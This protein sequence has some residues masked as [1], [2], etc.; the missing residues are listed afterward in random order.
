MIAKQMGSEVAGDTDGCRELNKDT[1]DMQITSRVA[2]SKSA[3][4]IREMDKE[5]FGSLMESMREVGQIVPIYTLNGEVVDGRARLRACQRLKMEPVVE[6]LDPS[7]DPLDVADALN[8]RRRHLTTAEL[9]TAASRLNKRSPEDLAALGISKRSVE[10]ADRVYKQGAPETIE[11]A[12]RGEI[13]ISLASRVSGMPKEQ[14]AEAVSMIREGKKSEVISRLNASSPPRKQEPVTPGDIVA[15]FR[16]TSDRIETMRQLLEELQD[17]ELPIVAGFIAPES[18]EPVD[19]FDKQPDQQEQDMMQDRVIEVAQ[20]RISDE[21]IASPRMAGLSGR[22]QSLATA[23]GTIRLLYAATEKYAKRGDI[24]QLSDSAIAI[25]CGFPGDAPTFV[26]A[27]VQEGWL[28]RDVQYR[29]LVNDWPSVCPPDIAAEVVIG[30]EGFAEPTGTP[31][32]KE[33]KARK[34][35]TKPA[36][37]YSDSFLEFWE[38]YPGQRK[39][40]KANAWSKW[41]VA[42]TRVVPPEGKTAEEWLIIR[43]KEFAMSS[44]GRGRYCQAPEV[45]LNGGAWDDAPE[46]WAEIREDKPIEADWKKGLRPAPK[47]LF[48]VAR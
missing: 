35:K 23:I 12:S 36:P 11:A 30:G 41:Q 14:Q 43:C 20:D 1:R 28:T 48:E 26:S 34:V 27:L 33:P 46:A 6:K 16:Q 37:I 24:G 15:L 45:W 10:H 22:L 44:K 38:H 39:M 17:Y 2:I 40:N 18:P 47:P 25:A 31:A 9:A 29:L 13:P 42:I 32:F 21:M 3:S 4:V 19:N 7:L 5:E 8:L